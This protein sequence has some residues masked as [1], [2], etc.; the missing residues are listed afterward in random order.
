[1]FPSKHNPT[2]GGRLA[3]LVRLLLFVVGIAASASTD[4]E[5]MHWESLRGTLHEIRQAIESGEKAP[6]STSRRIRSQINI[7]LRTP[8]AIESVFRHMA[9]EGLLQSRPILE[10]LGYLTDVVAGSPPQAPE[11]AWLDTVGFTHLAMR[12]GNYTVAQLPDDSPEIAPP[13]IY[14][15]EREIDKNQEDLE[16]LSGEVGRY[17]NKFEVFLKNSERL[18]STFFK[19]YNTTFGLTSTAALIAASTQFDFSTFGPREW[20]GTIAGIWAASSGSYVYIFKYLNKIEWLKKWKLK[21]EFLDLKDEYKNLLEH[22]PRFVTK[23]VAAA[24]SDRPAPGVRSAGAKEDAALRALLETNTPETTRELYE[25]ALQTEENGNTRRA[26]PILTEIYRRSEGTLIGLKAKRIRDA[27][28]AKNKLENAIF[29]RQ[30][31]SAGFRVVALLL[32]AWAVNRGIEYGLPHMVSRWRSVALALV[33]AIGSRRIL[34]FLWQPLKEERLD[35][36]FER[37]RD[38]L[39]RSFRALLEIDPTGELVARMTRCNHSQ[40]AHRYLTEAALVVLEERPSQEVTQTLA[41]MLERELSSPDVTP[42]TARRVA[43]AALRHYHRCQDQLRQI[44]ELPKKL[45]KA[46]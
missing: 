33:G 45:G 13:E 28:R 3:R 43:D 8:G 37:R 26:D 35:Y 23:H 31:L 18:E 44:L 15:L 14:F 17:L 5:R 11:L 27:L 30:I 4:A 29:I 9:G 25:I 32:G 39:I 2:F 22:S 46:A 24:A 12:L 41:A 16:V 36:L 40:I 42:S 10:D 20:V 38:T 6:P 7:L 1:M 34:Q 19:I 21:P